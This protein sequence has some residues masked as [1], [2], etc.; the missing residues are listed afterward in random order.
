[1]FGNNITVISRSTT[2]HTKINKRHI[3]LSFHQV[4]EAIAAKIVSY[5]FIKG[6][7]NPTDILSKYWSHSK[8]WPTLKPILFLQGN[9]MHYF[10]NEE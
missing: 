2:P 7:L 1:M 4:R 10:E 8:I 5:H 3:A 9:T 6:M